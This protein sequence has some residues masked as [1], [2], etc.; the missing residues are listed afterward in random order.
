MALK[1]AAP[2]VTG[3]GA[4]FGMRAT[5]ECGP[6][7]AESQ[8]FRPDFNGGR[9]M[10]GALLNR[11]RLGAAGIIVRLM[12]ECEALRTENQRLRIAVRGFDIQPESPFPLLSGAEVVNILHPEAHQPTANNLDDTTDADELLD[13]LHRALGGFEERQ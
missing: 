12:R 8:G 9:T 10:T 6:K 5:A 2:A 11:E 7:L 1:N 13:A 3:D 4:G